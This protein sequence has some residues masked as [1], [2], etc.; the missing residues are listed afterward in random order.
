[1]QLYDNWWQNS[2]ITLPESNIDD[3]LY[4][5]GEPEIEHPSNFICPLINWSVISVSGIE[6]VSFLQGQLTANMDDLDVGRCIFSSHCNPKGR[7]NSNFYLYRHKKEEFLLILPC[8]NFEI[9][10]KSLKKYSIFSKVEIFDGSAKFSILGINFDI[11]DKLDFE[12]IYCMVKTTDQL[13]FIIIKKNNNHNLLNQI[14]CALPIENKIILRGEYYWLFHLIKCGIAIIGKENSNKYLPQI[15][16]L[17]ALGGLSFNKGCYTGQEV[18]ARTKYRGKVKRRCIPF[19]TISRIQVSRKDEIKNNKDICNSENEIIG[20]ILNY[21]FNPNKKNSYIY[22]FMIIKSF[23]EL[24]SEDQKLKIKL[25]EN[26]SL[27]ITQLE[28]PYSILI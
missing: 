16:N 1:M 8:D 26:E 15:F 27:E 24:Q 25:S 4:F 5:K 17:D 7:M 20:T 23:D 28:L 10:F 22:G 9:A 6:S 2:L 11:K 18:I 12:N 19:K 3:L 14:L 21:T 13:N